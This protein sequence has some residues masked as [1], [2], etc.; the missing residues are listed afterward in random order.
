[1]FKVFVH[2][3]K[4]RNTDKLQASIL[5]ILMFLQIYDLL[6]SPL[7]TLPFRGALYKE[8]SNVLDVIRIYP[9]VIR[10]GNIAAY[11]FFMIILC[12]LTF[13]YYPL[14]LW[15]D[16]S[17]SHPKFFMVWVIQVL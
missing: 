8:V 2:L 11:W 16:Y 14:I 4:E 7:M 3:T 10:S 12:I 6:I 13:L 5:I 17:I 15:V 1:M 9:A